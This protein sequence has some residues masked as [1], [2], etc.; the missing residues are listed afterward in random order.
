[1]T[2]KSDI[3]RTNPVTDRICAALD[4]PTFIKVG[5]GGYE[6]FCFV[7]WTSQPL[8]RLKHR[9]EDIA[10]WFGDIASAAVCA[11]REHMRR[12]RAR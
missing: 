5:T 4:H 8:Q 9:L 10:A 6:C 1:M 12:A 3:L 11:Y 2:S 7:W